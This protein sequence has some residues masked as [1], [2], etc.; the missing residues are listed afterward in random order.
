[1][2]ASFR[3]IAY[4]LAITLMLASAAQAETPYAAVKIG[5]FLPNG[6]GG[7]QANQEGGL[8]NFDSGF[9]FEGG[10]GFYVAPYAIFEFG[11]GYYRAERS[12]NIA[13]TSQNYTLGTIPVTATAKYIISNDPFEFGIG[14]GAGY[15]F[16]AIDWEVANNSGST[17]GTALGYHLVGNADYRLS[18]AVSI[19]AEIKWISAK[20]EIDLS[21]TGA[22]DK[23]WEIGGTFLNLAAKFRF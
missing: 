1:M 19:G 6:R 5:A 15:Y 13:G 16:A 4:S 17:H 3:N 10:V 7:T 18:E 2:P 22:G 23:K 8:K 20:P 14:A 9:N 11:T 21:L 12:D